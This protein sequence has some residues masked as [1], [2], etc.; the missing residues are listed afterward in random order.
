V[1]KKNEAWKIWFEARGEE[2]KKRWMRIQEMCE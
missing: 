2:N 1:T